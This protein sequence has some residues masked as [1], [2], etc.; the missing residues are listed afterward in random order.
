MSDNFL[1]IYNKSLEFYN[2]LVKN[3]SNYNSKELGETVT[4]PMHPNLYY[5]LC[6][7]SGFTNLNG[8]TYEEYISLWKK[9][10]V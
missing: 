9:R 10:C 1:E 4:Q 6:S 3:I 5:Q 8:S 2:N 7:V